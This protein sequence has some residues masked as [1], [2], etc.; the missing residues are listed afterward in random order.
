VLGYEAKTKNEEL[1]TL[2]PEPLNSEIIEFV[3]RI[4]TLLGARDFGRIDIKLDASGTPHFLEANLVPG[5]TP[6]SSYF[7]RALSHLASPDLPSSDA[8]RMSHSDVALKIVE[9]G[10][11]RSS[12]AEVV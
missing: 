12:L 9:L 7:P 3:D 10:L 8:S 5:M 6:N 1:L 11:Y 4:F 2:V